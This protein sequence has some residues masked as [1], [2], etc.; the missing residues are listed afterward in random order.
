LE[1]K[2]KERRGKRKW[3]SKKMKSKIEGYSSI[4][5]HISSQNKIKKQG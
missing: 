3:K 4:R 1:K 2:K 5:N